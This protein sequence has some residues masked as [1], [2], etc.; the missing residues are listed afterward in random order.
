MYEF[1]HTNQSLGNSNEC[2][3]ITLLILF[4]GTPL[5]SM[6]LTHWRQATEISVLRWPSAG[7]GPWRFPF[8]PTG[9]WKR[10]LVLLC[11]SVCC[12]TTVIYHWRK[13]VGV[14]E[15][16]SQNFFLPNCHRTKFFFIE[17][18]EYQY[19]WAGEKTCL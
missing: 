4:Q 5:P 15:L 8:F 10:G 19:G 3:V 16:V 11:V 7:D 14:L 18:E 1:S 6:K 2:L 12:Y 17:F 9:G 13:F